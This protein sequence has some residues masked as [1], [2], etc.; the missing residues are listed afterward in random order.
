MVIACTC[1]A[2][3]AGR[4]RR[5]RPALLVVVFD[6]T[7]GRGGIR[8]CTRTHRLTGLRVA[9]GRQ[10]GRGQ[11]RTGAVLRSASS[12]ESAGRGVGGHRQYVAYHLQ[13]SVV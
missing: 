9:G 2:T 6:F 10:A 4:R 11:R 5:R 12:P 3:S 8:L 7:V 1:P 13:A